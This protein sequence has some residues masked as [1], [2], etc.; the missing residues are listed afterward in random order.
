MNFIDFLNRLNEFSN[1]IIAILTF[2][3]IFISIK[4]WG[5]SQK[6]IR[7]NSLPNLFAKISTN[8]KKVFLTIENRSNYSAYDVEIWAIG[9]FLEKEFPHKSF[10]VPKFFEK[11]KIDFSKTLYKKSKEV[12]SDFEYYGIADKIIYYIFPPKSGVSINI[13]FVN[14]PQSI[15]LVLQFRDSMKNNYLNQSFYF[16]SIDNPN[17]FKLSDC[18][19]KFNTIRRFSYHNLIFGRKQIF[20]IDSHKFMFSKLIYC[21]KKMCKFFFI[22]IKYRMYLDREIRDIFLRTLPSTYQKKDIEYG[23]DNYI[24]RG[25]FFDLR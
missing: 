2:A 19:Y 22:E 25:D 4:S 14:L 3:I 11:S 21:L 20:S 7:L 17:L 13:D 23:F 9:S 16:Q 10:I 18:K 24:S 5:I 15:Y 8:Q 12:F 6:A 1:L